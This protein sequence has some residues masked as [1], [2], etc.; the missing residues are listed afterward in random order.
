MCPA[1]NATTSV[2]GVLC[3]VREGARGGRRVC[4]CMGGHAAG[5][6]RPRLGTWQGTHPSCHVYAHFG[7]RSRVCEAGGLALPRSRSFSRQPPA[8]HTSASSSSFPPCLASSAP[9]QGLS[10]GL[11]LHGAWTPHIHKIGKS[12]ASVSLSFPIYNRHL[13][14][15]GWATE[16]PLLLGSALYRT[17]HAGIFRD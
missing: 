1:V 17:G 3:D 2:R 10:P 11:G 7:G 16:G 8:A 9:I 15:N 12:V 5:R 13:A 14:G 4:T 6:G